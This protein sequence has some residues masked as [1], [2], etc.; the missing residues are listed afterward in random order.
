MGGSQAA[1]VTAL[2]PW[3]PRVVSQWWLLVVGRRLLQNVPN[4]Q[5]GLCWVAQ[6]QHQL[7]T[8]LVAALR[9]PKGSGAERPGLQL[10]RDYGPD[11]LLVQQQQNQL[12]VH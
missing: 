7:L 5:V 10:L 2:Y 11:A 3:V 12:R 4:S 9:F 6:R 8:G 1:A